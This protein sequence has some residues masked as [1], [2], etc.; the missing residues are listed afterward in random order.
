LLGSPYPLVAFAAAGLVV[1]V[2]WLLPRRIRAGLLAG[3]ALLV[4][5]TGLAWLEVHRADTDPASTAAGR[6]SYATLELT[7]TA[8][9]VPLTSAFGPGNVEQDTGGT[10]AQRYRIAAESNLVEVAGKAWTSDVAVSVVAAG[11][12]WATIPVGTRMRVGG[13]LAVDEFPVV[14][15]VQLRARTPPTVL[16]SAPWWYRVTGVVRS[17][18]QRSAQTLAPDPA[19]LLPGLVVGDTSGIDEKLSADAKTTGLTHLLAV[20]GSHFA[21]LCGLVVL[22]LRG[23][24][25]RVAVVGGALTLVGLVLLVGPQ[26]SVLRA[27]VMGAVGLL[28]VL[29]GRV[30]TAVPAL[31]TAVI[32]LLLVDPAL[33]LSAGFALSVLAT[34]GLVLLAPPWAAALRRRGIPR[35]WAEFVSIPVAA[36]VTTLP[37]VAALSGQVSLASLPANLAVAPVVPIAL[38]IGVLC[39]VVGP[40]WPSG[41]DALAKATE[42]FLGWISNTAHVLARQADAAVPWPATGPG[43]LV[44]S[45]LV[46]SAL[47]LLRHRRI[48]A[49]ALAALTGVAAILLPSRVI[50]LPGW[51]APGWL[52]TACDVG[53]GDAMVL[54]TDEPGVAV[55]VDTGPD[56]ALVDRCLDRLGVGTIALLVL[57]HLH[58]DHIDGLAGA[59]HGRSVGAIGVG[60]EVD[61]AAALA[62]VRRTAQAHGVPLVALPLGTRWAAG[63]LSLQVLGPRQLFHGTDS[64]P[65][66]D[67]VVMMAQR[68]GIRILMTGDVE[69]EAQQQLLNAGTDLAADILKVPHHGSSKDLPSFL[70]AIS[71][72]VA[73]IGV[74]KDNDYGHPS[75]RTLDELRAVGTG[76]ILRTDTDGDVAVSL[77]NGSLAVTI[78]GP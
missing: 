63:G 30:R 29:A 52:L 68:A 54:A 43:V 56:P 17:E 59:L 38:V 4:V 10:Q 70:R 23:F 26:P 71:P 76:T 28:A 73:V 64:D 72:E 60:P 15:G 37:V 74:G 44:L 24:G 67:S 58:A 19:G 50:A 11:P 9:A 77:V 18:L 6:G 46:L 31:A 53:Q 45:G 39:A 21:I 22:A 48:R 14:P 3:A 27:A 40:W 61:L 32:V 57:T 49:L 78:R 66:N 75:P 34:G 51:P 62:Q 8:I 36:Q 42:P 33:A 25:P 47:L 65:N 2:G 35:G 13:L 20:S 5:G 41:G 69:T 7:V 16:E 1:T 55:L 12:E